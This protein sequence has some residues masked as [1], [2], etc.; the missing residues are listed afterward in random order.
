MAIPDWRNLSP[1]IKRHHYKGKRQFQEVLDAEYDYLQHGDA[2]EWLLFEID[3][4][5]FA[6]DFLNADDIQGTSWFSFSANEKLLLARMM[7]HEHS[8][9]L[10]HLAIC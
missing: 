6:H 5:T 10:E 9:A 4:E 1:S 8:A 7:T 3:S 2:G